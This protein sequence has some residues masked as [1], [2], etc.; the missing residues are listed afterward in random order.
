MS[1]KQRTPKSLTYLFSL[2][3]GSA[4]WITL[5]TILRCVRVVLSLSTAYIMRDLVNAATACNTSY[6]GLGLSFSEL[7]ANQPQ[8]WALVQPLVLQVL[9]LLGVILAQLLV[10]FV[11]SRLRSI[12]VCKLNARI[13][14]RLMFALSTKRYSETLRFHTGEQMNRLTA[15][16]DTVSGAAT[17]MIPSVVSMFVQIFGA[18]IIL[19]TM[20]RDVLLISLGC[21]LVVGCGVLLFRG[22]L[23]RLQ[24]AVRENEGRVR[25]HM[26]ESLL[27]SPVIK[28]FS[29]AATFDDLLGKR[30]S[31]SI[32]AVIRHSRFTAVASVL[33][34][35]AFSAAYIAALGWGGFAIVFVSGFTY[36]SLT[37]I[38]QLVSQI[39]GPLASVT[40]IIPRYYTIMVSVERLHELELLP[41][42]P[43]TGELLP[44]KTASTVTRVVFSDVNFS[45]TDNA[46]VLRHIDLSIERGDLLLLAGRSGIGK[47]TL[48]KLLLALYFPQSGTITLETASGASYPIGADTR[49][50]F[51]YVPQGNLLFSGTIRENVCLFATGY[52]DAQIADALTVACAAS[53][54]AE[55]PDGLETRLTENGNGISEGQ[56]QRLAVARALLTDAPILLLDE[57]TSALDE[58]TEL[59]MLENIRNCGKTCLLISHRPGVLKIATRTLRIQDGCLLEQS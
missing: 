27:G 39:R 4:W 32:R 45:Y 34:S 35:F 29:A 23:K 46:E 41:D 37:A 57:A 15:D 50:A 9:I 36:G 56:A 53:F 13:Q 8:F 33:L 25:S 51:A 42:E 2:L 52:T 10:R 18:A 55:L 54:V 22:R 38:L 47:T 17:E 30:Q 5:I 3:H 28:A 24:R 16:V 48:M 19:F 12:N 7:W 1:K 14:R 40:D 59:A 58:P 21:G 44:K 6:R 26:Q 11:E 43:R 49:S 20:A 31:D